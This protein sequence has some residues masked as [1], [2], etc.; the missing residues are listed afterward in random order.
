[1]M[2]FYTTSQML[3]LNLWDILMSYVGGVHK[4]NIHYFPSFDWCFVKPQRHCCKPHCIHKYKNLIV[5]TLIYFN[6]LSKPTNMLS[7]IFFHNC[8]L[9]LW[10]VSPYMLATLWND[11]DVFWFHLEAYEHTIPLIYCQ[12][13][14]FLRPSI[15]FWIDFVGLHF[16][17]FSNLSCGWFYN[18][19]L[20][21]II[22]F[23]FWNME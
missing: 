4:K 18:F 9:S 23:Y 6:I 16:A 8:I 7:L 22:L 5:F 15:F 12:K 2:I 14:Q 10:R 21:H 17:K 20:K 19:V 1:M 13:R 3:L 11:K